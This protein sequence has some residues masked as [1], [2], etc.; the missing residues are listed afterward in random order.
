[1]FEMDSGVEQE[2]KIR[3]NDRICCCIRLMFFLD[4]SIYFSKYLFYINGISFKKVLF[5]FN[6]NRVCIDI[7]VFIW[8]LYKSYCKYV[9]NLTDI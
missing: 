4:M 6:S 3:S 8:H 1:M 5:I 9:Q 2:G 7:L